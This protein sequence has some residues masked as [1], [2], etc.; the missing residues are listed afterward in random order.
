MS[1]T[2][3]VTPKL[4]DLAIDSEGTHTMA[5]PSCVSRSDA[6]AF[7]ALHPLFEFLKDSG[8]WLQHQGYTILD[9]I[10][11]KTTVI[12]V[13]QDALDALKVAFNDW[14]EDLLASR[15]PKPKT[16]AVTV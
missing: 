15:A 3:L 1:S 11:A 5:L 14:V 13:T 6:E 7:H 8:R 9:H 4:F 16:R 10:T 12:I 2:T